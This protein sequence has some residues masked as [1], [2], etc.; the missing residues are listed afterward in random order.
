MELHDRLDV[1]CRGKKLLG[2]GTDHPQEE[3][4]TETA[5]RMVAERKIKDDPWIMI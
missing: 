1:D 4:F 2:F 3:L 5:Q